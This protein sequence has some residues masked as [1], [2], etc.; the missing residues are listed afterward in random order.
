MTGVFKNREDAK[1]QDHRNDYS[2]SNFGAQIVIN[3]IREESFKKTRYHVR[4]PINSLKAHGFRVNDRFCSMQLP[5]LSQ[6]WSCIL[7]LYTDLQ[8]AEKFR[9]VK[10]HNTETLTISE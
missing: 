10:I 4:L 8:H 5:N 2:Y 6:D 9:L 7:L 3:G 1:H